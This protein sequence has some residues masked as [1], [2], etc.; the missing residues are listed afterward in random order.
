MNPKL[1][2]VRIDDIT[3]IQKSDP[4]RIAYWREYINTREILPHPV[5]VTTL[6]RERYL[7]LEEP[8][9]LEAAQELKLEHIPVQQMILRHDEAV[10]ASLVVENLDE[11]QINRF[12]FCFP[13]AMLVSTAEK[14][15]QNS[16]SF[17]SAA[18]TFPDQKKLYLDFRRNRE[19]T[20]NGHLY[21]FLNF[22]ERNFVIRDKA[23]LSE[24]K[25]ANLKISHIE[26][27][28][29]FCHITPD[30]LLLAAR[31]GIRFPSGMISVA[32]GPRLLGIDFPIRVLRERAPLRE[33]NRFL[34]DL[35]NYR[36][37]SG[38]PEYFRCGVCYLNR[39]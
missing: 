6:G 30:D 37:R 38:H 23:P 31:N 5:A 28:I 29:D 33:K 10:D 19:T 9:Y 27:I 35:L 7:L 11:N 24:L 20:L 18:I 14:R 26:T 13:R 17:I 39:H 32:G 1:K 21:Y 15:K 25:S 3:S 4:S 2:I 8:S 34:I 36:I 16:A 22:L 12:N